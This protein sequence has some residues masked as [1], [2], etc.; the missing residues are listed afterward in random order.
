MSD[1]HALLQQGIALAKAGRHEEARAML[2]QVIDLDERN[3]TAWLW[4]SGVVDNDE[5]R[6][7]ALENVLQI[8]PNNEWAKRGLAILGRSASG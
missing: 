1:T 4:I 5:D 6:G 3:E 8:N 7:I 2:L